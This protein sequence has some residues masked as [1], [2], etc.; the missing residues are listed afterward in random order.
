MQRLHS[1][2]E[3]YRKRILGV[4][5]V[6][7]VACI[8]TQASAHSQIRALPS[9]DSIG[10]EIAG[11][12]TRRSQ[13]DLA[14]K[15]PSRLWLP[16]Q[17]PAARLIP[18]QPVERALK[19]GETQEFEIRV[20][21]GQ[22]I[23]IEAEPKNI[24]IV[25]TLVAADGKTVV[26]MDGDSNFLWRDS[27]SAIVEKGGN[28]KLQIKG[29]G[30][31]EFTG[32]FSVKVAELRKPEV[33]DRKR[34]EAEQAMI[35]AIKLGKENKSK[36]SAAAFEVTVKLFHEFGDKYWEAVSEWNLAWAYYYLDRNDDALKLHNQVLVVFRNIKDRVGEAAALGGIG[37]LY[38]FANDNEAARD[39]LESSLAII[40]ELKRPR[41]EFNRLNALVGVY[42][43]LSQSDKVSES[44][45]RMLEISRELKNRVDERDTLNKLGLFLSLSNN[46]EGAQQYLRQALEIDRELKDIP[47]Q[48]ERL[49]ILAIIAG[50]LY[51][52]EDALA[53][54]QQA[55]ELAR[56]SKD[57]KSE[58][59]ALGNLGYSYITRFYDC[60]K[61]RDL[62]VQALAIARE[63]KTDKADESQILS[64]LVTASVCLGDNE[65]IIE[66]ADQGLRISEELK[67]KS[68]QSSFLQSRGIGYGNTGQMEKAKDSFERATSFADETKQGFNR[69]TTRLALAN[70]YESL[71][72]YEKEKDLA[73]TALQITRGL[74]DDC[75]ITL[76]LS[77]VASTYSYLNNY[78]RAQSSYE[79][80]LRLSQKAKDRYAESRYL[81]NLGLLFA[82]QRQFDKALG[83]FQQALKIAEESKIT[84]QSIYVETS[85]GRLYSSQRQFEPA[86][87]YFETAYREAQQANS[88]D[89]QISALFSLGNTYSTM[90]QYEKA[91]PY[92]EQAL[93][94]ARE[95]KN[96]NNQAIAL[97]GL[98]DLYFKLSQYEKALSYFKQVEEIAKETKH[99]WLLGLVTGGIGSINTDLSQNQRAQ[100]NYEQSLALMKDV[101]DRAG[102][103]GILNVLGNTYLNLKDYDKAQSYYEQSLAIARETKNKAGEVSPLINIGIAFQKK[104]Q[105]DKAQDSFAAGLSLAR[106]VKDREN[107]GYALRG[108]GE[109][110]F[111]LR[112]FKEAGDYYRQSLGIAKQ[113]QSKKLEGSVLQDLMDLNKEIRKPQ[114]AILYGKL[115]V[116]TYQE[117]RGNI[118]GFDKESQQSYVK[119]K[120][121]AYRTLA[122]I[123]ISQDRFPEAQAVLQ[124]LKEEEYSQLV[125]G[126]EKGETVP[127]SSVE[128][129]SMTKIENLISLERQRDEL[130]KVE[131]LTPEQD[132]RANSLLVEINDANEKLEAALR[133]LKAGEKAAGE[134]VDEFFRN[135]NLKG[136]LT[137][138]RIKTESRVAVLYVLVGN[139]EETQGKKDPQNEKTK[140]GW[141][142]LVTENGH[143][144]YPINVT[145]FNQ[146]VFKFRDALATDKYDPQ[147]LAERLYNALFRQR[148]AK[149]GRTLEQDLQ[150]YLGAYRNKTVMWS[151]DGVL[152]YIP[153]AALH[154]GKKY[155]VEKYRNV[156]FTEKSEKFL[157]AESRPN[158]EILGLGVSE[159]R[160]GFA[161]LPGVK[162]ELETIVRGDNTLQG[163]LKG[164]IR[165]KDDFKKAGFFNTVAGG[166]YPV[167]HIA[168]HYS[169]KP[170]Q[171]KDSFLLAGDGRLTFGEMEKNK[172]LFG[173]VDLLTLSA[174]DTGVSDNGKEAEGFS[175][176]AQE[177]G[178]K[179]VIASLWQVSDEGTPE[180]MVRF[181][182]L[183]TENPS[184]SKGE[185]F[186]QAQLS[187][188]GA[189]VSGRR[190][191][192]AERRSELIN[193]SSQE[194][195]LPLF[196][197]DPQRP[198]SHPHYW[199]SFILIG[200]WR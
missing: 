124:L 59:R 96:R 118:K 7:G 53:A 163:I 191:G 155:L 58:A 166:K 51:R 68:G 182:R 24:D 165:L 117:I 169:F 167:V 48:I 123:L 122:D 192:S 185:A 132:A 131:K 197:K 114:A 11:V 39:H 5:V 12:V 102:E 134:R 27:V 177:L 162:T 129:D 188:L 16:P 44:L 3:V 140:F 14:M 75:L 144:A 186:R 90:N 97:L 10:S 60:S 35:R 49:G 100:G 30:P 200:N 70:F 64:R 66:Y 180:L 82:R 119:D 74:K 43:Y 174:C 87:Q 147:P 20:K 18:G 109:V 128:S 107:E 126:D 31:A 148:S 120:E 37:V 32:G 91:R 29:V 125:R 67:D 42:N 13:I 73:E 170:G 95:S 28:Y 17:A 38:K 57:K 121:A 179:S 189:E 183:R 141:I 161:A 152:R 138:L 142:I 50:R 88:F 80:A 6:F 159:S 145:D 139:V 149:Q 52:D 103:G 2:F 106:D 127:Y 156:L 62:L 4:V 78:E 160:D 154:D 111:K 23:R 86:I 72:E 171:Q 40:R 79:E 175:Y 46:N 98:G 99:R 146:I 76:A 133:L 113:V 151:L 71:Q 104:G 33:A 34:I 112:K 198:F 101:L 196:V 36:E 178:A 194:V 176:K 187:L 136:V 63:L 130:L 184:M 21:S 150:E 55:M 15:S 157:L 110:S 56:S 41:N 137:D 143:K 26:E 89:W 45:N 115:A 81:H 9:G 164:A 153:M 92:F 84:I 108:L 47:G 83:L 199:A 135:E 93:E 22:F 54:Q 94:K 19:S 77:S 1:L 173:A 8:L 116:N 193:L 65:K 190:A 25:L 195:L 172:N 69:V 85:I 181:Y 105:F 158:W 168:S 61:G